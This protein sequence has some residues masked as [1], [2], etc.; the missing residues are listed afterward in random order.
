MQFST[1]ESQF[2]PTMM[3]PTQKPNTMANGNNL[4]F[5]LNPISKNKKK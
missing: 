3:R 2:V 1:G 5:Q 4:G